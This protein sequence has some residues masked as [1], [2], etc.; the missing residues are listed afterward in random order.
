[1]PSAIDFI[2]TPDFFPAGI[3]STLAFVAHAELPSA[4]VLI[5]TRDFFPVGL[6][7]AF[8]TLF[9]PADL[10]ITPTFFQV[11]LVTMFIVGPVITRAQQILG[12]VIT[13]AQ[14][15]SFILGIGIS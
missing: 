14:Q 7:L 12:L 8:I 6:T 1:L 13:R 9:V 3:I 11:G 10:I 2:I 4:I 5:I 15:I